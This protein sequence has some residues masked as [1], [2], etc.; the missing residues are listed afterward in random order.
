MTDTRT[1]ANPPTL[2]ELYRRFNGPVP[3]ELLESLK[4]GSPTKAAIVRTED[5]MHF[6][7]GLHGRA[8]A[9][10]NRWLVSGDRELHD[11]NRKDAVLYFRQWR[12]LRRQLEDL[13]VIAKADAE[14]QAKTEALARAERAQLL[15]AKRVFDLIGEAAGGEPGD[16]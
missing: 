3:V 7:R 8:V 9:S 10:S 4:Y 14:A 12:G 2:A 15:N 6:F 11:R 13:R 16:D 5:S 1:A